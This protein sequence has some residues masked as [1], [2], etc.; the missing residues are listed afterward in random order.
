MR[1]LSDLER[2]E[3]THMAL[4]A[5]YKADKERRAFNERM[6]VK[7]VVDWFVDSAAILSLAVIVHTLFL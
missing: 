1:D 7:L 3:I 6:N 5:G 4:L 2:L